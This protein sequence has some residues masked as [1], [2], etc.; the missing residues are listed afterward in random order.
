MK[1]KRLMHLVK[2]HI[3]DKGY[4]FMPYGTYG[5]LAYQIDEDGFRGPHRI[6]DYAVPATFSSRLLIFY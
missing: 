5:M 4:V 1:N 6:P 3:Q 2:Q